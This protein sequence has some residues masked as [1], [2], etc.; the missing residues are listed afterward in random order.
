MNARIF[1]FT[2]VL[3]CGS[4]GV[5]S[6]GASATVTPPTIPG[7]FVVNIVP[8]GAPT[9]ST[10]PN[11]NPDVIAIGTALLGGQ[12]SVTATCEFNSS[13]KQQSATGTVSNPGLAVSQNDSGFN[14]GTLSILCDF[15]QEVDVALE[16]SRSG[17][18]LKTFTGQVFQACTFNM[19]FTDARSST[20]SGTIEVNAK[21][22]SADGS[23]SNKVVDVA[24][25]AKV[26]VTNGAGAFTGYVGSGT[27]SQ[28]QEIP[29]PS[30]PGG[31]SAPTAST[32]TATVPSGSTSDLQAACTALGVSPCTETALAT[33]CTA[34]PTKCARSSSVRSM[35]S[36]V[37]AF[38][39]NNNMALTLVK[40]AG[41][42]R[43]LAPAPAAGSPT[44]AAKV[45][46]NTRV[47]I[48]ATKG[49]VCTVKTNTGKVVGKATSKGNAINI[50]PTVNSY[51]GAKTLQAACQI[52]GGKFTSNKVK[53]K[54]S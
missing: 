13:G 50:K 45:K 33:F 10:Q 14:N 21:L 53:I 39:T 32:P 9:P 36:G 48:V 37:H 17:S 41:A 7:D 18:A 47:R 2:A 30:A 5:L 16:I 20:L 43:I 54:L 23:V 11:C 22:G 25:D 8:P 12:T 51:K 29:I 46:S 35:S 49:A 42:A 38:A 34:N 26:F 4:I 6:S 44:A 52:K 3:G 24:F 27:F 19:S 28:S 1:L 31:A 15:T 40:K